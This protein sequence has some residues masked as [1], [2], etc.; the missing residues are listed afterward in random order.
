MSK[1]DEQI[2][3]ITN[4]LVGLYVKKKYFSISRS[5]SGTFFGK[6]DD[7]AEHIQGLMVEKLG[8]QQTQVLLTGALAAAEAAVHKGMEQVRFDAASDDH[9]EFC[10][11]L[12][13]P[14]H[15]G[16][17]EKLRERMKPASDIA[18]AEALAQFS[19]HTPAVSAPP[20]SPWR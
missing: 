13:E 1:I 6:P 19:Q 20:A 10:K 12:T 7:V 11:A 5:R 17:I 8:S 4:L 14:A 18:L 15:Q 16:E 2:T 3:Q 9:L